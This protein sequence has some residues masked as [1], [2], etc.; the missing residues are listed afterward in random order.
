MYSPKRDSSLVDG[1]GNVALAQ[2]HLRQAEP[3]FKP[4]LRS[5]RGWTLVELLATLTILAV[6][7]G[8]GVPAYEALVEDNRMVNGINDISA[9]IQ[10]AR[11]EALKRG[12]PVRICISDSANANA[13]GCSGGS[14]WA[15]GWNVSVVGGDLLRSHSPLIGAES[16]DELG[17]P[18]DSGRLTFDRLGFTADG[19]TIVACNADDEANRARAIIVN[20][21]GQVRTAGDTGG[22]N[23]VEDAAGLNVACP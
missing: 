12:V 6:L 19:R 16:F 17:N 11:S 1:R 23:I 22:D 13:S 4:Q 14:D 15:A 9:S 2:A 3:Q 21:V 5:Q 10:F 7:L 20:T 18:A 8:T